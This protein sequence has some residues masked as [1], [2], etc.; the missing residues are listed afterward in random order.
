MDWTQTSAGAGFLGWP[1]RPTMDNGHP[2]AGLTRRGSGGTPDG[3]SLQGGA[4]PKTVHPN[5]RVRIPRQPVNDHDIPIAARFGS[6]EVPVPRRD[7]SLAREHPC[8]RTC[9]L[10]PGQRRPGPGLPPFLRPNGLDVLRHRCHIRR[11]R[12]R[13]VRMRTVES[14]IIAK[15]KGKPREETEIR[16]KG[17]GRRPGGCMTRGMLGQRLCRGVLRV[18]PGRLPDAESAR[19]LLAYVFAREGTRCSTSA[20]RPAVRQQG[21]SLLSGSTSRRVESRKCRRPLRICDTI[22]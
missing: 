14:M 4:T 18:M 12:G 13:P 21:R 6:A 17:K 16:Q 5:G 11:A 10:K 22:R 9:D 20:C 7:W 8:R 19:C 3:S 1:D 15:A 2:D